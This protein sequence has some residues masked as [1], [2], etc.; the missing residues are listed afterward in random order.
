MKLVVF[1]AQAGLVCFA[2]ISLMPGGSATASQSSGN[3]VQLTLPR[4]RAD[5]G[6]LAFVELKCVVCHRVDGDPDLPSPVSASPG[7]DLGARQAARGP[8]YLATSIVTPSHEISIDPN[9]EILHDVTGL[10]SP[11][12]D[13]SQTM[14]VRQLV[15]LLAY[16]ESLG[17]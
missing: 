17:R 3:Q 1:L 4:G 15:N 5:A 9:D 11:M 13:F 8:D 10:M 7:P 6:R 12:G 14:T 2:L 16:L